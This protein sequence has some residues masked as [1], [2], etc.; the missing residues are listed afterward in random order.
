MS[1]FKAHRSPMIGPPPP[2]KLG[3]KNTK[4]SY[5]VFMYTKQPQQKQEKLKHDMEHGTIQWIYYLGSENKSLFYRKRGTVHLSF[6][7]AI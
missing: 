3:K 4:I 5:N 1:P 6:A 7:F 2:G